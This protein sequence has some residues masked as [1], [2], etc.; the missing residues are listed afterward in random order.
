MEKE[1]L[2]EFAKGFEGAV[3]DYPFEGDF[4]SFVLR[5]GRGGSWF[6]LFMEAPAESLL[7][8]CANKA[9]ALD[10]L[11]GGRRRVEIVNL[12]CDPALSLI[13]QEN[14][15][16]VLPA[17]HMNKRLWIT[18]ILRSD[19]PDEQLKGLTELSYGLTSKGARGE[20]KL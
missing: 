7:R 18:V 2:T 3:C 12:K 15:T 20:R 4:T 16:G 6:A 11:F 10:K 1:V 17:Y 8:C 5:H 14:F 19:V 13:L 9:A